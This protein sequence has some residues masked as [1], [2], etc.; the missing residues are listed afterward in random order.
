MVAAT[1]ETEIKIEVLSAIRQALGD[2]AKDTTPETERKG[3]FVTGSTGFVGRALVE[4]LRQNHSVYAPGRSELDLTEGAVKLDLAVQEHEIE[5]LVHLANPRVFNTNEALGESLL[6]LKNVLDV[7]RQNRIKLIY[8]SNWEV[9]AG[10]T[11]SELVASETDPPSPKGIYGETKFLSE[12]LIEQYIRN[13][14]LQSIVVRSA[15][16]YG[17]ESDKPK[18]IFNFM[19]K[20][21]NDKTIVTH[22]YL[23]GFPTLDLL[24]VD[25][26]TGALSALIDSDY[27][28][29]LHVGSGQSVSTA[30]VANLIVKLTDSRSEVEHSEIQDYA[31]KIV[32]DYTRAQTV[33]GWKP[34]ILFEDGL[35]MLLAARMPQTTLHGRGAE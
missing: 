2:S 26:L 34:E 31:P 13:Y 32:M 8:V 14:G 24:H 4:R 17:P 33:I 28:G 20:A 25:D 9:Y 29:T 15:T 16:L 12:Q 30:D 6:M 19:S 23:N 7:S 11:S 27:S 5:C 3:I 21:A 22:K 10:H 1:G 18:F 35:R